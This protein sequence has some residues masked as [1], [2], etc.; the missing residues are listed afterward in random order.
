[1]KLRF[2]DKVKVEAPDSFFHE[3]EGT[4]ILQSQPGYYKV[5]LAHG[6][7]QEFYEEYLVKIKKGPT[8]DDATLRT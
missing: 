5:L 4:V 3:A 8:G 6:Q 2:N 7:A 1:M